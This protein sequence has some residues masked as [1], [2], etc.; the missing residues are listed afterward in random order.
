MGH[1]FGY[2][3][4]TRRVVDGASNR[5]NEG[6]DHMYLSEPVERRNYYLELVEELAAK[7]IAPAMMEV[8]QR[9]FDLGIYDNA[10][11]IIGYLETL[12]ERGISRAMLLLGNIYYTGKGVKQ[13]Y[14]EAVKWYEM[15]AEG[16]DSYGLCNLGYCYY[17]G[18]DIDV[19][20]KRAYD[21]FSLS[22]YMQNPNAMYKLGDMFFYGNHVGEDKDAAFY[23]YCEA[24]DNLDGED[25][26]AN[27]NYRLGLCYLNGYGTGKNE[28]LALE[29]LQTAELEFFRLIEDGDTFA[30]H[31]LPSV[32]AELKKVREILYKE[33]EI[34]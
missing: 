20:Y 6:V 22:A 24:L 32:K 23:W 5:L 21:C 11:Q 15:A 18:R 33:A 16:L 3:V 2:S 10:G 30:E 1:R 9:F 8:C 25:V 34:V 13:S 29:Y 14:K 26:V 4:S 31:T 19:N 28:L 17:Y 27:I 12:A 7:G